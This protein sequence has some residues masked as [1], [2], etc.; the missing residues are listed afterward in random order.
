MRHGKQKRIGI[1]A[2]LVVALAAAGEALA[3]EYGANLKAEPTNYSGNCPAKIAF[4][5]KIT[6]KQAGRVQYKFIRSDGALAPVQTLEFNAPGAKSVET[7]WTLGGPNLPSYSGWQAIEI[8]HPTP[9]QS[10]KAHFKVRCGAGGADVG[11]KPDLTVNINGPSSAAPGED[12]GRALKLRARNGGNAAAPGTVGTLAPSDGY[13]IDVVLSKDGNVPSGFATYSDNFHDDVLLKGGRAS[14]TDDLRA[15]A[16]RNYTAGA[17]IPADT[18]PGKYFLCAQIDPGNKVAES[19][20]GNNVDC[21]RLTV[22]GR[23]QAGNGGGRQADLV[24]PSV[25]FRKVESRTDARGG[26]YW[27]FNVLVSVKNQGGAAAGPFKVLLERNVGP[28]GSYTLACQ[29]CVI[30]VP[31]LAAG[32]TTTL[33]PRQ[34]NN[35]NNANSIFRATADST[36]AVAESNEGNN[37]NA[38]SFRP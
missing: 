8:V 9:F 12:I 1:V 29:T 5:G 37:M 33:P 21:D 13:M 10:N 38:E 16:S 23:D 7:T 31:G 35:A 17:T 3:R 36:G 34:F 32:A 28:G 6:A 2:V 25:Q 15:G 20:E 14:R 11:G 24:V 26:Q 19:N 4:T 27:I 22:K 18:P 30:D